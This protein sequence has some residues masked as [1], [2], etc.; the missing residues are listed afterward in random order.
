MG[1]LRFALTSETFF[2]RHKKIKLIVHPLCL[3]F[4]FLLSP[5]LPPKERHVL[6]T[7]RSPFVGVHSTLI[8]SPPYT[9]SPSSVG[10][11]HTHL[12]LGERLHS[13]QNKTRPEYPTCRPSSTLSFLTENKIFF[14]DSFF[15]NKFLLSFLY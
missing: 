1:F 3:D 2:R 7:P 11:V 14:F 5:G 9:V 10:S 12:H 4:P 6:W 15:I 8:V 13:N